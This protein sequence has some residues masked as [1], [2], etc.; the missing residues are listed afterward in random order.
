MTKWYGWI[1]VTREHN[2]CGLISRS[3]S[4]LPRRL[5]PAKER[6]SD[7]D[8]IYP[9]S[10]LHVLQTAHRT[11]LRYR[12]DL[13]QRYDE[14]KAH[15]CNV[16]HE[17]QRTG[18]V[19]LL[20]EFER[21]LHSKRNS[22]QPNCTPLRQNSMSCHRSDCLLWML[23]ITQRRPLVGSFWSWIRCTTDIQECHCWHSTSV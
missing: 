9:R 22:H 4:P 16:I 18:P 14:E 7:F 20:T 1:C 6:V 13:V 15:Q 2:R 12:C 19:G 3:C 11:I 23:S 5:F 10:T 8:V 21:L 17:V